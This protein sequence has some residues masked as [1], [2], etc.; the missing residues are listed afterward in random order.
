MEGGM[1]PDDAVGGRGE[2]TLKTE[3]WEI[4]PTILRSAAVAM[5]E[6]CPSQAIKGLCRVQVD[7]VT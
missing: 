3:E 5:L 1:Y 4:A 6:I 2:N 7:P